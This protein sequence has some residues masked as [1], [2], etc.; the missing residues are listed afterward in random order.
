MTNAE[1]FARGADRGVESRI[2]GARKTGEAAE[3]LAAG[4]V[5]L[6]PIKEQLV[7]ELADAAQTVRDRDKLKAVAQRKLDD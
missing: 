5:R 6:A 1:R 2:N 3:D 4:R 7:E